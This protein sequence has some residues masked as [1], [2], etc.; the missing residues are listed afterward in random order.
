[1][2]CC[3]A[4]LLE[5]YI[6]ITTCYCRDFINF[7]IKKENVLDDEDIVPVQLTVHDAKEQERLIAHLSANH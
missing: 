7:R 3:A 2:I 6:S 5:L 4:I 1:M